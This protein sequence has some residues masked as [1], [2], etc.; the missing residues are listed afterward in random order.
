MQIIVISHHLLQQWKLPSSL[1]D[2]VV[3]NELSDKFIESVGKIRLFT[4]PEVAEII[5]AAT[6]RKQLEDIIEA[7]VKYLQK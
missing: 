5:M 7:S 6:D 1:E 2:S 4:R 3:W